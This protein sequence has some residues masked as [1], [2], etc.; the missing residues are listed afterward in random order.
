M[1]SEIEGPRPGEN[2]GSYDF[3]M[4]QLEKDGH[5]IEV[6]SPDVQSLLKSDGSWDQ[7]KSPSF[8]FSH[9]DSKTGVVT[10]YDSAS[11]IPG[12]NMILASQ[13]DREVGITKNKWI[14]DFL[15]SLPL[16]GGSGIPVFQLDPNQ[17]LTVTAGFRVLLR[18]PID[19]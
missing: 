12:V 13:I 19:S 15:P 9:T 5:K 10:L 8:K 17:L 7:S 6:L 11:E 14:T 2:G 3:Y 18:R 4:R 1:S 16:Q